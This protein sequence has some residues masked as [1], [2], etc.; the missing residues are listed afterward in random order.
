[1]GTDN[2]WKSFPTATSWWMWK[3]LV[4]TIWKVGWC[5]Q[6]DRLVWGSAS[7]MV[8]GGISGCYH[9]DLGIIQGSLT[10]V[11]YRDQ[12]LAPHVHP[13]TIAHKDV[14]MFQQN[15]ANPH[16]A[17]RQ[18][19]EVSLAP[20]GEDAQSSLMLEVAIMDRDFVIDRAFQ[21]IWNYWISWYF[22]MFCYV[23]L[24]LSIKLLRL[25]LFIFSFIKW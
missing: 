8:W 21:W 6:W 22:L 24:L 11:C 12:I 10:E 23:S 9:T 25:T 4:M 13:F 3:G 20:W 5:L 19:F 14:E 16:I 18:P 1:M 2:R 15:N 7:I 17:H